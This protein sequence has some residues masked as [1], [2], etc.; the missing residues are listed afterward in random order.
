MAPPQGP[1][2]SCLGQDCGQAYAVVGRAHWAHMRQPNRRLLVF[3]SIHVN[4]LYS[5]GEA[6]TV[7]ATLRQAKLG[8]SALCSLYMRPALTLGTKGR[9]AESG[10]RANAFW[11][12]AP[13]AID[14]GDAPEPPCNALFVCS[15]T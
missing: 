6:S 12:T 5:T 15:G 11:P 9:G 10:C 4:A 13:F 14:S 1:L 7:F 3:C 2:R 8:S